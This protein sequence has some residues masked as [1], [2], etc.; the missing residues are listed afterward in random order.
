MAISTKA[1]I[2]DIELNDRSY[3]VIDSI[4]K[5]FYTSNDSTSV[6]T[7]LKKCKE[8]QYID[9]KS[10]QEIANFFISFNKTYTTDTTNSLS[11]ALIL[12]KKLLNA[13]EPE[14]LKIY[15]QYSL[16]DYGLLRDNLENFYKILLS[17]NKAETYTAEQLAALNAG[18]VERLLYLNRDPLIIQQQMNFVLHNSNYKLIK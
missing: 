10:L 9:T 17:K 5:Q 6:V 1:N 4:T 8:L 7:Q 3:V 2:Q 16:K 14:L 15:H 13:F 11:N 12:S 18:D